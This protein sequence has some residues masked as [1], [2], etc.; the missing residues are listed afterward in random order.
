SSN[1]EWHHRQSEYVGVFRGRFEF[2]FIDNIDGVPKDTYPLAAGNHFMEQLDTLWCQ[3]HCNEGYSG[4]VAAGVRKAV[5]QPKRNGIS[6]AHEYNW[7]FVRR[8]CGGECLRGSNRKDDIYTVFDKF[9][10]KLRKTLLL[11]FRIAPF[12]KKIL[13]F[14]IAQF[15]KPIPECS[16]KLGTV[17]WC[18][19]FDVSN[20]KDPPALL[21]QQRVWPQRDC[22]GEQNHEFAA[23]HGFPQFCSGRELRTNIA[24]FYRTVMSASGPKRT[25]HPHCRMSAFGGKATWRLHSE[26]SA[27]DPKRTLNDCGPYNL[28][29]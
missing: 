8:L 25:C 6:A 19:R 3:F 17:R 14:H 15:T 7:N 29:V 13:T 4:D 9:R 20:L 12:D 11:T 27:Y 22:A 5:D 16:E 1:L 10:G 21:C 23:F 28:L 26:M 24:G 2:K 18:A